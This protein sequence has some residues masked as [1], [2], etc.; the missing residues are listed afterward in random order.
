MHILIQVHSL[1]IIYI[2]KTKYLGKKTNNNVGY[3]GFETCNEL[4]V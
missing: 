1:A 2:C 4:Y 3:S